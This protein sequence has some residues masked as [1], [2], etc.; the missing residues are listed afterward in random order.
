MA[1]LGSGILE[2]AGS[3][4]KDLQRRTAQTGVVGPILGALERE[5]S[6]L[7]LGGASGKKP[8]TLV[9]SVSAPDDS[10]FQPLQP[11][12]PSG[13]SSSSGVELLVAES[14]WSLPPR[15]AQPS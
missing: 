1:G 9:A 4:S 3:W 6:E 15:V 11:L 2:T 10:S 8:P 13:S 7:S 14:S 12:D 5:G